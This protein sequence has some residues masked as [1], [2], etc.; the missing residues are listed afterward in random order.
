MPVRITQ[1]EKILLNA[2][3]TELC[4]AVDRPLPAGNAGY[5]N[6]AGACRSYLRPFTNSQKWSVSGKGSVGADQ[7]IEIVCCGTWQ[8]GGQHLNL[9][10]EHTNVEGI[11]AKQIAERLPYGSVT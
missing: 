7:L 1:F 6:E 10:R 2:G 4:L 9:L 8:P 3:G 5:S 11:R